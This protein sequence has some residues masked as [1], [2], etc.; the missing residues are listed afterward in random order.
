MNEGLKIK[1][2]VTVI[3]DGSDYKKVNRIMRNIDMMNFKCRGKSICRILDKNHPTI[4][5]IETFTDG[6][7][8]RLMK[9]TI[10]FAYPGLCVFNPMV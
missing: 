7:N 10:E 9:K 6:I 5:V 1:K 8:Y 2:F 3:M 4:K